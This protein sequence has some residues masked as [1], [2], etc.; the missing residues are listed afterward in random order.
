MLTV[1]FNGEFQS[2]TSIDDFGLALDRFDRFNQF[3]LWVSVEGGPSMRMLRNGRHAWLMYLRFQDDSGLVSQGK[4]SA[5]GMVP[6]VLANGQVDEYPLAW[7]I[8]VE[9]SY[10]ALAYFFVN[11]G[12]QPSWV[13]WHEV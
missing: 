9:Q 12:A 7:C 11:E 5:P 1:T 13:H 10:K 8:D 3:E 2:I 6:Y 4:T